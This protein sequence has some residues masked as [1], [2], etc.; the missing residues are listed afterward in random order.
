MIR[1]ATRIDDIEKRREHLNDLTDEQLKARFWELAGKTVDP[2]IDLAYKNT[3][4][5]IERSVVLRMGF[6]SIEAK[7]IVEKTI[8]HGLISKGAGHVIYRLS[9]LDKISIRDAGQALINNKGWDKVKKSFEV[10]S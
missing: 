5:A 3:T 6:S 10:S 9:Q 2:L 1:R 7:D 8:K 4:P